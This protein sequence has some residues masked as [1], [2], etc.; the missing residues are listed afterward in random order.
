MIYVLLWIQFIHNNVP[1]HRNTKIIC[2]SLAY[3]GLYILFWIFTFT[4]QVYPFNCDRPSQFSQGGSQDIE[5]SILKY[6]KFQEN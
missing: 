5:I 1:F 2:L 3:L 6:K 4:F